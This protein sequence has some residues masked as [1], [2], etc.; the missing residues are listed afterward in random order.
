[1]KN[2]GTLDKVEDVLEGRVENTD[3][4]LEPVYYMLESNIV[5]RYFLYFFLAN[6]IY[7]FIYYPIGSFGNGEGYKFFTFIISNIIAFSVPF[8]IERKVLKFRRKYELSIYKGVHK[9]SRDVRDRLKRE[10]NTVIIE[11]TIV[12]NEVDKGDLGYW[13]DLLE[14]G[15]IT[16]EEYEAKK[17]EI[18][19]S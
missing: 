10:A 1:M 14:K 17:A 2:R 16:T 9:E 5:V 4:W 18:L 7:A 8:S 6:L 11:Q 12:S 13:H 19:K 3:N 15:A